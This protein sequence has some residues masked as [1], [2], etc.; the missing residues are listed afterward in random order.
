MKAKVMF[1]NVKEHF[2]CSLIYLGLYNVYLLLMYFKNGRDMSVLPP[3]TVIFLTDIIL[4][5]VMTII[6]MLIDFL[7]IKLRKNERSDSS[8]S[9]E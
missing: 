7:I 2:I 5:V 9:D 3:K 6:S 4:V 1:K 8:G